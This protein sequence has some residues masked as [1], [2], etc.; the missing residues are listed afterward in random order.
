MNK[1]RVRS[2]IINLLLAVALFV[3]FQVLFATGVLASQRMFVTLCINVMLA[4][5]LNMV[6]GY[7]GQLALGHAGFMSVGA[8]AGAIF[9]INFT[10]IHALP[11]WLQLV[12]A[13]LVGGIVAA[14]VGI[15][16]GIPALRL[17]GDY[18]AIMTLGFGEIIRVIFTNLGITGKGRTMSAE[19]LTSFPVVFWTAVIMIALIYAFIYSRHGRAV[20]SIRDD[21]VAAESSGVNV[22]YYKVL[23]F[24]IAAGFAGVAGA[25]WSHAY[26]IT[27][28]VFDF[29]KS[30]DILIFVVL[31]GMGSITGSVVAASVLTILPELL[32]DLA[33]RLS[34]L[35][36]ILVRLIENRMVIYAL[37]L[38]I[39]MVFRPN[40]LFGKY[41]FSLIR[42]VRNA[43]ANLSRVKS[44]F[45]GKGKGKGGAA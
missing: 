32:R 39:M 19:K 6:C 30:I 18:L 24:A 8:Y 1:T 20:I 5:S 38:I 4:V 43:P 37:L 42:S 36:D 26:S 28:R 7:M 23:V 22:T 15:L 11:G 45:R 35:P 25:L 10:A 31:G 41:E 40:G 9:T 3:L 44:F 21:E 17:K 33:Y 13:M 12:M 34:W 16:I 29:N 27:P 2:Y 14:L